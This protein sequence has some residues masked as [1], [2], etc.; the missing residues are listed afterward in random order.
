LPK[1]TEIVNTPVINCPSVGILND[2]TRCDINL[3]A[4]TNLNV[5]IDYGDGSAPQNFIPTGRCT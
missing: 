3:S 4:G 2:Y 5:T 1:I